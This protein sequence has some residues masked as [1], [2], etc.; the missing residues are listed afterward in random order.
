MVKYG[1]KIVLILSVLTKQTNKNT[2]QINNNKKHTH[3]YKRSQGNFGGE[4]FSTLIAVM[5]L[6]VYAYVQTQHNVYMKYLH[7]C[8]LIIPQ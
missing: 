8:V 1:R 2:N 6:R 4:M 3:T 5:V 7:I